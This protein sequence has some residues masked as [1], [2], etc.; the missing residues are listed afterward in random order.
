MSDFNRRT[1]LVTGATGGIGRL[2]VDGALARGHTVTA[3]VRSPEV[4][5]ATP[6]RS[7][8][9]SRVPASSTSSVASSPVVARDAQCHLA[10]PIH[11]SSPF[12]SS[13]VPVPS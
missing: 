12:A 2:L 8:S 4:C 10:D 7:S 9:V 13:R 5:A 3:F 6:A 11:R 1:I